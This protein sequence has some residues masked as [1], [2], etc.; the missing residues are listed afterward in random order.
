MKLDKVIKDLKEMRK[1]GMVTCNIQL[2]L[3]QLEK[4]ASDKVEVPQYVADW[5]EA[6]KG[7]FEFN[8][9]DWIAFRDEPKKAKNKKFNDWLNKG[10]N[11]PIQTLVKMHLFGYKVKKEKEYTVRIKGFD[12]KHSLLKYG[13]FSETWYFDN[14]ENNVCIRNHHTRKQIEEAG[15]SGVFDNPMFEVEEVDE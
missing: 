10:V 7:D 3:D 4:V 14:T 6:H 15:L 9:W 11:T 2:F 13:E 1:A 8:V 5:Y 12:D